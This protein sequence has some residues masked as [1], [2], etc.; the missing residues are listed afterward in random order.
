MTLNC[1]VLGSLIQIRKGMTYKDCRNLVI[2]EDSPGDPLRPRFR[3]VSKICH[4]ISEEGVGGLQ[5]AGS[6]GD[7]LNPHPMREGGPK[8]RSQTYLSPVEESNNR[9]K[10]R[11]PGTKMKI[12]KTEGRVRVD[13]LPLKLYKQG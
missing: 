10:V 1:T 4:E 2:L 7:P 9:N 11:S 6:G 12:L 3:G 8:N 13:P 5:K